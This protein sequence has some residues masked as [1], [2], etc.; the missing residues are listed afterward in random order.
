MP[1]ELTKKELKMIIKFVQLFNK[2][3]KLNEKIQSNE[4]LIGFFKEIYSELNIIH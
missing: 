3:E 2:D 4:S 1:D